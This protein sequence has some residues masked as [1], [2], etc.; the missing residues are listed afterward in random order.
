MKED[1]RYRLWYRGCGEVWE[2]QVTGY[3]ESP[4]GI[5]L[6]RPELGL[7]EFGVNRRNNI[8]LTGHDARAL[9]VFRDANP[10]AP[11][12]ERYMAIGR[13]P[14]RLDDGR[15][16][17]RGFTSPD[18]IRWS[19]P[20]VDPMLTT[21]DDD[22]VPA[23]DSHN[24]ALWDPLTAQYTIYARGHIEPK[25]R[26]IRRSVSKDFREWTVPEFIDL[27]DSPKEHLYK[28]ACSQY[29]R[30]PHHYMMFPK[31]FLPER[32]VV[33]TW[34]YDGVSDSVFM[35]SRDGIKWDRCFMEAFVRPGVDQDNWNERNVYVGVGVVPTSE[36]ELSL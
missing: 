12:E 14:K 33:P 16:T 8:V 20:D 7:Y 27:G 15:D 30:A 26:A 1:D 3:A 5:H 31:R 32:K 35:T 28:N 2:D 18:G 25:V 24:V 6:E 34:Q 9:C 21:P 22:L 23:F 36:E 13:G 4:D 17:L 29:F 19:D 10:S 11:P